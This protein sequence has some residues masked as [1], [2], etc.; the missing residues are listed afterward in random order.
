M[1][2]GREARARVVAQRVR[3]EDQ[4]ADEA[5]QQPRQP[6][7]GLAKRRVL[8]A[9]QHV[10]KLDG[11][12]DAAIARGAAGGRA[13]HDGLLGRHRCGEI[14]GLAAADVEAEHLVEAAIGREHAESREAEAA[15]HHDGSD[16]TLAVR[17]EWAHAEQRDHTERD[18]H[19]CASRVGG[20]LE[21]ERV[22][23]VDLL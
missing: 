7:F 2:G 23:D 15:E 22:R 9:E 21:L 1:R 6:A 10:R 13:G 4:I 11:L 16:R 8:A 18:Q 14:R 20:A 17:H 3:Q 19:G 5:V 12:I